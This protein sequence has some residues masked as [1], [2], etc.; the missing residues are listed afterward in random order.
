[1][2]NLTSQAAIDLLTA[3]PSDYATK[4]ALLGLL[5]RLDVHADGA[6]QVRVLDFVSG[7][8]GIHL[9]TEGLDYGA[10]V[11]LSPSGYDQ[12]LLS[13][14]ARS[15]ATGALPDSVTGTTQNDWVELGDGNDNAQTS[16]GQDVVFGG[17][18]NDHIQAGPHTGDASL[19]DQDR[20]V[21]GDGRDIVLGG[22]DDDILHAGNVGDHL[23]PATA[24][25]GNLGDWVDGGAGMD[26]IHGGAGDDVILGDG[27]I[28]Q[29]IRTAI[30]CA[31]R[32]RECGKS[33]LR[34]GYEQKFLFG[35]PMHV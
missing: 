9:E 18:G 31:S 13:E 29:A 23:L 7:D 12:A 26:T 11:K 3:N 8:L 34:Y 27:E 5:E 30:L 1:M 19:E 28:R 16:Y 35:I 33:G 21:G 32:G 15:V 10:P 6:A 25:S 24:K 4:E 2:G 17:A 22:L 20:V 14:N